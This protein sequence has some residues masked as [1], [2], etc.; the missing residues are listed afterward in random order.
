LIAASGN[1]ISTL[2][3]KTGREISNYS[4]GY[5]Q[6]VTITPDSKYGIST[7]GIGFQNGILNQEIK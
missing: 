3:F 1:T 4:F 7:S 2:D 6:K 5:Q